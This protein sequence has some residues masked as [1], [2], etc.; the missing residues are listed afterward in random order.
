MDSESKRN[1]CSLSERN[2]C[3][4]EKVLYIFICL[5]IKQGD[6]EVSICNK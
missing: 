4:D 1:T 6:S 3:G 5:F 2:P